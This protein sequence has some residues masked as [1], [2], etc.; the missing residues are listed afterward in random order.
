MSVPLIFKFHQVTPGV[1]T[2]LAVRVVDIDGEPWFVAADICTAL[3]LNNT[4]MAVAGLD[5]DERGVSSVD[6]RG[7]PQSATVI[8]ESGLYSLVLRSRKPEA[9]QF[10]RW[11]THDV[12]P[13]IRKTGSYGVAL[14]DFGDPAAAARA[15]A[16]EVDARRIAHL[17][18]EQAK[19]A[20]EF[21]AKYVETSTGNKTFR[22]VCKLLGANEKRFKEFLIDRSVVYYLNGEMTPF[23]NHL[24]AGRFSV[25]A[26]VSNFSDHAYNHMTFTPKG[27]TWIAGEW[28]KHLAE[29]NLQA[30]QQRPTE[31]L[32]HAHI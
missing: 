13:A 2:S 18:L 20:V 21:V 24:E 17:A 10:K 1:E 11:I 32:S 7:G 15:W 29:L 8:S 27:V 19:P 4:S 16:D 31:A 28:G 14:P 9:K 6:T 25:K 23:A 22:Q 30:T 5:D 3:E 12:L 26:G